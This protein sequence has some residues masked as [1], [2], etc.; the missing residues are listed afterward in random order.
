MKRSAKTGNASPAK[1]VFFPTPKDFR[2]W[3]ARH[4]A[5]TTEQWVGFHK[6]GSGLPSITW[7]E[8]VDE[9]LCYG[10]IDGIR[11]SL[12]ETSYVIRFTP[13]RK[14]SIWSAVN[15]G[16]VAALS[17]EGRMRTAGIRAFEQRTDSRTGV[18]AFE[19]RGEA[20]LGPAF[21]RIFKA[22]KKA[23]EFFQS[24]PPG[25]RR[26]A[27][28]WVISAKKEETRA[29]RLAKLIDDSANGRS[30]SQLLRPAGAKSR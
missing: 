4:H 14:G 27:S 15:V 13:R 23:W 17:A 8:S 10:W 3:L 1:P 11:K 25:Y 5:S 12:G 16:R 9:A 28:W 19:Q 6:K 20:T 22:D 2:A 18:Y 29:K 30:I 24:L 7:P 26:T 21:E